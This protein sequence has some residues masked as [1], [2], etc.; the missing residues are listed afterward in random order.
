[1]KQHMM[2]GSAKD[3]AS[4]DAPDASAMRWRLMLVLKLTLTAA[5]VALV[6]SQLDLS[7]LAA[8]LAGMHVGWC[9]A[10]L[11]MALLER[12][13]Q[14]AKWRALVKGK[15]PDASLGM[16]RVFRIQL[17]ANFFGSFLPSSVGV[18]AIRIMAMRRQGVETVDTVAATLVDRGLIVVG[19]LIFGAVMALVL[20]TVLPPGLRWFIWITAGVV[21]AMGALLSIAPMMRWAGR[22]M[23][24][25]IGQTLQRKIGE[26][27][28]AMH[29]YH[30][31][32]R[33]LA[34]AGGLTVLA[35]GV[36]LLFAQALVWTMGVELAL[37]Q[38]ALVWPLTWLV[39]MLPITLGAI[40]LQEGAYIVLFGIF[41]IAPT[42]AVS[43]S[44]LE[45]VTSRLVTVPGGLAW[46]FTGS[47]RPTRYAAESIADG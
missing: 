34:V 37:W 3:T 44:L 23:G 20:S 19:Q 15:A 13:I 43:V 5:L 38:L 45:H 41:G 39:T 9:A 31:Q 16:M 24:P 36:R 21:L 26:L 18:D 7:Q 1:M 40:G 22:R 46:V 25:L 12:F 47:E 29:S 35:F 32:P 11:A 30:R 6:I 33:T 17:I 14:A 10:A 8:R 42:A 2:P 28:G 4:T 27:Y